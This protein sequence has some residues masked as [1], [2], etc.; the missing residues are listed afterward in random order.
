MNQPV[1]PFPSSANQPTETGGP[2]PRL[3]SPPPKGTPAGFGGRFAAVIIDGFV[4]GIATMPLKIV[5]R[6]L[7]AAITGAQASTKDPKSLVI[8]TTIQMLVSL[9]AYFYYYGYFYSTRGAT[10]GKA[11]MG[12]RVLNHT[13][14]TYLSY[15]QSFV[16]E[17]FGKFVSTVTLGVG[18]I[19]VLVRKD[20]RALHDLIADSEVVKQSE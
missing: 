1:R 3:V 10:P 7:V 6:Y 12:L 9:V 17:T 14:G 16:R 20:K 18:Y 15:G 5:V 2:T 19:M 11:L 8:S 13:T 4:L